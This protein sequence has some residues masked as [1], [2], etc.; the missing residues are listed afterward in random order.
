MRRAAMVAL[1][2][3][4]FSCCGLSMASATELITLIHR[5]VAAE[6]AVQPVY[7]YRH[8]WRRHH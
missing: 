6:A 2:A 3:V 7:Y 5:P 1:N 4:A 8:H